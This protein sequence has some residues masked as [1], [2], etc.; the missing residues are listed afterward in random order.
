MEMPESYQSSAFTNLL[1]CEL[2]SLGEGSAELRLGMRE[3]LRK[4]GG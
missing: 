1:G 4:R 2:L 3:D